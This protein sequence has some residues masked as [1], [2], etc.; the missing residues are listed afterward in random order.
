[1]DNTT[2]IVVADAGKARIFSALKARLFNSTN[3]KNLKLISEHTHGE[4]RKMDSELVS[5]RQGHFGSGT[6]EEP[7]DPK[8]HQEEIFA[9]EITKILGHAHN[10]NKFHD[11]ILIAPPTFMGLLNKHLTHTTKQLVSIRIEKDYTRH[12]EQQLVTQLQKY[13]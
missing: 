2:W 4:S 12:T 10:E 6:F 1:M 13:L 5:D 11:L 9:H 3:P 8:R 7:T